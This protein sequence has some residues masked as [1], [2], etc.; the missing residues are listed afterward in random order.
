MSQMAGPRGNIR[1]F[2]QIWAG[3]FISLIGSALTSF[4]LGV[5]VYRT[6]G[7]TTQLGLIY[8]LTFVP[9]ILVAPVVGV[10]V[11]RMNRGTALLI[12]SA[13]G[14]ACMAGLAALNYMGVLHPWH[15]DIATAAL[16]ILRAMQFP[17]LSASTTMLVPREQIG[18]ANGM[19]MAA[20]GV[21]Q[22]LG[23]VV[24][25]S[26][27]SV[28]GLGG[29]LVI[30]S[31][32]Y[33]FAIVTLLV[34]RI[35][36]PAAS[37]EGRVGQ[38]SLAGEAAQ[39]WRYVASRA[40]LL[41]L[42]LF[43]AALNFSV[44]FVDVLI[45]PLVLSFSRAAEL[46]VVLSLAGIGLVAG[47]VAMSI[48]G[49]PSRRI[50]GVLTFTIVLGFAVC[51]GALLPNV[52]LIGMAAFIFSFSSAVINGSNRVI[53]QMKV[54]PDLQGRVLAF[55]S[56]V[57]TSTL[58][59]AYVL[60]GPLA[61]HVFE[62]LLVRHGVL[63]GSAGVVVGVGHGRGIAFLLF[64]LGVLTLI[65]GAAGYLQPRLRKVET[66]LPDVVVEPAVSNAP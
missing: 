64:C 15:V 49:G 48:W 24:A 46:G 41:R 51:L 43:Y 37:E 5:F 1:A 7:S 61:D 62:P 6:T 35:P 54:Q 58:P 59:I 44:G 55:E 12:C 52:L 30:D 14:L 36:S 65:I 66:E 3:Q 53:W 23:P 4:A 25:G 19:V 21:S 38:G 27:L 33:G 2:A 39:S 45:T 10:L 32:T 50:H 16:S 42:L 60:A 31:V 18:R 63:A 22:V 9:G 29:L 8:M 40:G 47:S 26:L 34:I 28:I 13:G 56:M 11:D 17:A 57:A 20:Q